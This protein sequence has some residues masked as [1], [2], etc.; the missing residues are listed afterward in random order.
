MDEKWLESIPLH[1]EIVKNQVDDTQLLK[2]YFIFVLIDIIN[3]NKNYI[4]M[5]TRNLL[6]LFIGIVFFV[7]CEDDKKEDLVIPKTLIGGEWVMNSA[8]YVVKVK[9]EHEVF[10]L[11]RK[12]WIGNLSLDGSVIDPTDCQ[13]EI[14]NVFGNAI[15]C[16]KEKHLIE[17]HY[18]GV[19]IRLNTGEYKYT[20]YK[21]EGDYLFQNGKFVAKGRAV[22]L[23]DGKKYPAN[24]IHFNINIQAH[25]VK[26]VP[27][28]EYEFVHPQVAFTNFPL[29][30]SFLENGFTGIIFIEGDIR[31]KCEG[32]WSLKEDKINLRG[33]ID[34]YS[35]S[36]IKFEKNNIG[37]ELENNLTLVE[38]KPVEQFFNIPQD[39]VE[40]IQF[41]YFYEK[42]A[43]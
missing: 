42:K 2:I 24:A 19:N 17:P 8:N 31:S 35:S 43:E 15:L 16:T 18:G 33:A 6:L 4:L 3:L 37:F 14:N 40:S 38:D 20:E 12:G 27:N 10:D 21:Y 30:L 34:H 23:K 36:K 39:D 5:Q 13:L 26:L 7:A 32:S 25:K 1:D 29:R 28:Q 11:Y 41:K 9:K 22:L